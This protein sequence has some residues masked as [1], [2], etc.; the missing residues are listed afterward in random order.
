MKNKTVKLISA[1]AMVFVM[2]LFIANTVFAGTPFL[3]TTITPSSSNATSSVSKTAGQILGVVQVVGMAVAVIMLTVLGIKY[4]S[5][6]P[7]EKA[8]YKKG[9]T[10]YV[11]G[12][13]ILFAASFL[14]GVIKNFALNLKS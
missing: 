7:N 11:I 8:D 12:A 2:T 14:V 6:S 4:V 9:M 3:N 1:I 5:A 10:I 13:V